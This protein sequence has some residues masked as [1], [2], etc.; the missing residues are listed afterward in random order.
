MEN[1]LRTK[2]IIKR[3]KDLFDEIKDIIG[4]LLFSM[5]L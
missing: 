1:K 3:L 5:K 2:S 4:E